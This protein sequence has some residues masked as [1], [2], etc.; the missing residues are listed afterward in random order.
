MYLYLKRLKKE[1]KNL[2]QKVLQK[3]K[4]Q[5]EKSNCYKTDTDE[6]LTI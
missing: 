6:Q 2:F 5:I 1:K 4:E 3:V